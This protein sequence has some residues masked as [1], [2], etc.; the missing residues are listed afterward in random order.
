MMKM[1]QNGDL[2]LKNG[3]KMGQKWFK[4][5][6]FSA[7]MTETQVKS[8]KIVDP[9]L[10][11]IMSCKKNEIPAEKIHFQVVFGQK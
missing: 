4:F 9:Q 7:K 8:V 5:S 2:M 6:F 1:P 3:S 10:D 11:T